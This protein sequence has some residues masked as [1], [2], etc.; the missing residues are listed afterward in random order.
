[1]VV[2][3]ANILYSRRRLKKQRLKW[4]VLS[5]Q[6]HLVKHQNLQHQIKRRMEPKTWVT[7]PLPTTT[8]IHRMPQTFTHFWLKTLD[9]HF[10]HLVWNITNHLFQVKLSRVHSNMRQLLL[11]CW[12]MRTPIDHVGP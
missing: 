3:N 10:M 7:F 2:L 12:G 6:P 4:I 5:A 9:T 8:G 11:L 1:M